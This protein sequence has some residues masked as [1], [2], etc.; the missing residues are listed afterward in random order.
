MTN[1]TMDRLANE[2][3]QEA[4]MSLKLFSIDH[5]QKKAHVWAL[6][7]TDKNDKFYEVQIDL[8]TD[9]T[10]AAIKNEIKRQLVDFND[11]RFLRPH[12]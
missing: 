3:I 12:A 8:W 5:V 7:F 1:E 10:E 6:S 4:G 2:A 11:P 9:K